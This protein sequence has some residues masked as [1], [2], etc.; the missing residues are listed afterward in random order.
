MWLCETGPHNFEDSFEG[1]DRVRVRVREAVRMTG[2]RLRSWVI[3]DT[4]EVH[5]ARSR[6]M[7]VCVCVPV[8]LAWVW[9]LA[10]GAK[11]S[12]LCSPPD[13]GPNLMR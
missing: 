13:K 12:S 8:I 10:P 9:S 11:S 2:V 1:S 3:R 6:G 4:N 7:R 5:K